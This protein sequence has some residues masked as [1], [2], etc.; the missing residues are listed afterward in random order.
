MKALSKDC[1]GIETGLSSCTDKEKYTCD[2]QES[3]LVGIQCNKVSCSN[4]TANM[5]RICIESHSQCAMSLLN[6]HRLC[7][8]Y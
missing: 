4:Y 1:Y 6:E 3:D 8:V 2:F 7:V 5:H